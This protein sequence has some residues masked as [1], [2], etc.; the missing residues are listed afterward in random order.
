MSATRA[1]V[2]GELLYAHYPRFLSISKGQGT[3]QSCGRGPVKQCGSRVAEGG[4][5]APFIMAK[6]YEAQL[7]CETLIRWDQTGEP[8]VLWTADP[9]IRRDWES[10]GFP[11]TPVLNGA[12][13]VVGWRSECPVDRISYKP[14]KI[15]KKSEVV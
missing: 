12:D 4:S 5:G 1:K 15:V 9:K 2:K 10:Y 7:E 13:R 6:S 3:P 8:A 14:L 11:I